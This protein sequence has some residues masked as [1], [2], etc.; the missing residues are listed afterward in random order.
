[1]KYF[2]STSTTKSAIAGLLGNQTDAQDDNGV[3]TITTRKGRTSVDAEKE[4]EK[5]G[6][7]D[8]PDTSST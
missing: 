6:V 4:K 3:D 1:M 2:G 8:L 5:A 7:E